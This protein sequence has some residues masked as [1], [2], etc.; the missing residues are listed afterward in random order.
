M[1]HL[2]KLGT[3]ALCLDANAVGGGRLWPRQEAGPGG[4][5]AVDLQ[6]FTQVKAVCLVV[7][8]FTSGEVQVA[9]PRVAAC[10]SEQIRVQPVPQVARCISRVAARRSIPELRKVGGCWWPV[11]YLRLLAM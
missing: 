11:D 7:A 10:A 2:E 8:I 6:M 3:L 4:V 5:G 1:S 9:Y